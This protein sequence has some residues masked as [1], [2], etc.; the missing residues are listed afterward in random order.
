MDIYYLV[1]TLYCLLNVLFIM[2]FDNFKKPKRY[3]NKLKIF[4]FNF[5][6]LKV[7]NIIE[8]LFHNL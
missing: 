5:F 8:Q 6:D 3:P 4:Y 2:L 1:A 7:I